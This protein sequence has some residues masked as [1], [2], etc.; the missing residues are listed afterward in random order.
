MSSYPPTS[1]ESP[2]SSKLKSLS[3]LNDSPKSGAGKNSVR[4]L[5]SERA[6]PVGGGF[7]VSQTP[8]GMTRREQEEE[9][10]GISTESL[11]W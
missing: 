9:R 6:L 1:G 7:M 3:N 11:F 10:G 2:A 5:K 8:T 4:K